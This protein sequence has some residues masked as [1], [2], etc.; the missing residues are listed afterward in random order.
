MATLAAGQPTTAADGTIENLPGA[1]F[2]VADDGLVTYTR[3]VKIF[4]T[5]PLAHIPN[6]GTLLPDSFSLRL[7]S[8][9]GT[10]RNQDYWEGT[11][12]YMGVK[13]LD[14]E[15]HRLASFDGDTEQPHIT[16]HPNYESELAEFAETD[17]NGK[18]LHFPNS[19]GALEHRLTGI[20]SYQ[21][22]KLT[23][24]NTIVKALWAGVIPTSDEFGNQAKIFS[25]LD[26]NATLND[27]SINEIPGADD[28]EGGTINRDWLFL[29]PTMEVFGGAVRITRTYVL[30][31]PY[32]WNPKIYEPIF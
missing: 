14:D 31:G 28:G 23:L 27:I 17:A 2:S 5:N 9:E 12:T 19:G 26:L 16:T 6:K 10:K 7:T 22:P 18:F 24:R 25:T 15:T 20:T 13:D 3:P 4:S 1:R 8:A 29:R 30:S 11:L 21:N 32:G